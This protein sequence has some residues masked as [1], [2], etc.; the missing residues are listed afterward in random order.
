MPPPRLCKRGN[1][2]EQE[3]REGLSTRRVMGEVP[4]GRGWEKTPK[5]GVLRQ[6]RTERQRDKETE[7][8]VE[9]T[10]R[11]GSV[12]RQVRFGQQKGN[13]GRRLHTHRV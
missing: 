11:G 1:G 5:G 10:G 4:K 9:V 6:R 2:S 7:L 8:Q 3:T 12:S 13:P